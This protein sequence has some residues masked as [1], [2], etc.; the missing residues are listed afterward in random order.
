MQNNNQQ[1]VFVV[2]GATASGKS[3][4]AMSLAE[5]IGGVIIN[6]DS[7]QIYAE[8]QIIT[9]RPTKTDENTVPHKLYGTISGAENFNV[10]KWIS[11]AKMEIEDAWKIGKTPILVGG[12][13]MYIKSLKDGLS[14]IPDITAEVKN[15]V[16]AKFNQLGNQEF[17]DYLQSI[18]APMAEKLSVGDSQRMQRA[19]EVTLQTGR[20]LE[21]W[22]KEETKSIFPDAEFHMIAVNMER[23]KLYER[24][25]HRFDAMIKQGAID[26]IKRL[27][28]LNISSD[29][30]IMKSCGVPEVMAYLS[31]DIALEQAVEKA[32]QS[33]RNYAKRQITWLNN[34]WNDLLLYDAEKQNAS[35]VIESLLDELK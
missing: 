10:A 8:L 2:T 7:M 28:E 13:G 4:F 35:E 32:K 14:P 17:H 34:Q 29:M 12:T 20:S 26:E 25:N 31:G 24:I 21:A 1:H 11:L 18:D 19:A 3:A 22:Q 6:A 5:K 33:S 23:E 9:A 27:K 16:R 15:K 30:P